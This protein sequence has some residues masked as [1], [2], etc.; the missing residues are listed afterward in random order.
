MKRPPFYTEPG[1]LRNSKSG[2]PGTGEEK[3]GKM[4]KI[5]VSGVFAALLVTAAAIQAQEYRGPKIEVKGDRYDFGKV[6]QGP[7]AAHT[8]EVRNTGNE[9]L[10]IERVQPT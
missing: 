3:V 4:R 2:L 10:V 7:P 6:V 5:V 9:P 1:G 8:F